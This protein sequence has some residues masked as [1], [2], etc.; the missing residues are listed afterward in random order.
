MR[1][2]GDSIFDL[3]KNEDFVLW[4]VSPR[5]ETT[6]YWSKW[7]AAHPERRQDVELARRFILSAQKRT[8][9][10]MPDSDYDH[11]LEKI[12]DHSRTRKMN[13]PVRLLWKPLSIAAS[14]ALLL[15]GSVFFWKVLRKESSEN[16]VII[17]RIQKEAPFGCKVTTK[18]P[19]G[20]M[21]ILNSGSKITFPDQFTGDT[22]EVELEGEAFFEVEHH[23]YKPF[24][25]KFN[26]DV[27]KVL[28][29]S[30]GIRTYENEHASRVSVATGKVSFSTADASIILNPDEMA[31]HD[32]GEKRLIKKKVDPRESFGWKDKILYFNHA[33]FDKVVDELER[34]YGVEI[35]VTS[36]FSSRGTYSGEFK[37]PT[38]AQVLHSISYVYRFQFTI[39]GKKITLNKIQ[40]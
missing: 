18:L 16:Q 20:S 7:L 21:V 3:L 22:R 38:L 23:P 17:T 14:I 27:V 24:L 13:R 29:T 33:T 8:V 32:H 1:K 30:F 5:E 2:R 40:T 31:V 39:D 4:V 37:N 10:K 28:G 25:V 12:V 35:V 9:E 36:D 19:D 6:H 26:Q 15:S 34:W 11:V